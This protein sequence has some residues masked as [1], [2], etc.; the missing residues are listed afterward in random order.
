MESWVNVVGMNIAMPQTH[1]NGTTLFL[2]KYRCWGNV[3]LKPLWAK[4][5]LGLWP[6]VVQ[7]VMKAPSPAS[8]YP[9]E[10][11]QWEQLTRHLVQHTIKGARRGWRF[12]SVVER[13]PRKRKALG[14]VPSSEK[15]KEPKKKKK[16]KP[17]GAR[18][19]SCVGGVFHQVKNNPSCPR[20]SECASSVFFSVYP[21]FI[22]NSL[23]SGFQDQA[24]LDMAVCGFSVYLLHIAGCISGLHDR[25]E[26]WFGG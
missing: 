23:Q 25:W 9:V 21:L 24:L 7:G 20:F 2:S 4:P 18:F 3:Y 6:N 14:S 5:S 1:R 16:K 17:K 22:P 11:S 12:S 13:L 26:R 10:T 19:P 15:K 8:H